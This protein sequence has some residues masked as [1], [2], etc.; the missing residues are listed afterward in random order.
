MSPP[1]SKKSKTKTVPPVVTGGRLKNTSNSSVTGIEII[2]LHPANV[3][4]FSQ[5]HFMLA[6]EKNT[7]VDLSKSRLC[8]KLKLTKNGA[9]FE[10]A[11]KFTYANNIASTLFKGAE[12][13]INNQ[14]VIY[15]TNWYLSQYIA[16]LLNEPREY[17]NEPS[18]GCDLRDYSTDEIAA[19]YTPADKYVPLPAHKTAIQ[20]YNTLIEEKALLEPVLKKRIKNMEGDTYIVT[21]LSTGFFQSKDLLPTDYNLTLKLTQHQN[22]GDA[23]VEYLGAHTLNEA[24]KYKMVITDLKLVLVRFKLKYALPRTIQYKYSHHEIRTHPVPNTKVTTYTYYYYYYYYYF[25]FSVT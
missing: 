23:S 8:M 20:T 14:V 4:D 7:A 16:T 10:H 9:D 3:T 12:L 22:V 11:N 1:P 13:Y 2:D 5:V 21:K 17:F 19:I 15:D 18:N 25:V 24:D 6:G